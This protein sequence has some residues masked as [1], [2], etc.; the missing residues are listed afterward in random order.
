MR[1]SAVS[2]NLPILV[3]Y[4]AWLWPV[5]IVALA[6]IGL[7]IVGAVRRAAERGRVDADVAACRATVTAQVLA[8]AQSE[9]TLAGTL[10]GGLLSTLTSAS[11]YHA[12][13]GDGWVDYG[14]ERL[15]LTGPIRVRHGSR[16]ETGWHPPA[17]TPRA[18]AEQ[19]P[20]RGHACRLAQVQN[21]DAVLITGTL[22]N[23]TTGVDRLGMRTWK[24]G[25]AASGTIEIM[26]AAPD[27]AAPPLRWST[28][29]VLIVVMTTLATA[30]MVGAGRLALSRA[31]DW[32]PASPRLFGSIGSLDP[33]V[34][35]AALPGARPAALA[36]IARQLDLRYAQTEAVRAQR[37]A[38]A[39]L[40]GDAP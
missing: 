21:G 38:L 7:W 26:A 34:I 12:R 5:P 1:Y 6:V 28:R 36:E 20:A 27:V 10:R 2:V 33:A 39:K 3:Q 4:G 24:L 11:E 35:A 22:L 17:R 29:L 32:D 40:L 25:P 23:Q 13:E 30:A 14:G 15:E 16:V 9:C 37:A 18:I 19:K 31:A 8:R